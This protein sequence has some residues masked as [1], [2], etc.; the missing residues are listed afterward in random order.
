[1]AEALPSGDVSVE[2][3]ERQRV[4]LASTQVAL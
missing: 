3:E 4:N 2:G 1:M